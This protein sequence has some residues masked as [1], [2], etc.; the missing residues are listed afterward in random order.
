MRSYGEMVVGLCLG[1]CNCC[2]VRAAHLNLSSSLRHLNTAWLLCPDMLT[3]RHSAIWHLNKNR[4]DALMR[5]EVLQAA[6]LQ[7]SCYF[8]E[9]SFLV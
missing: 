7:S 4:W 1:E 9:T 2:S 6:C 8:K 3:K 5:A